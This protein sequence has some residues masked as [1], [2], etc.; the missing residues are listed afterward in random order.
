MDACLKELIK[1]KVGKV[2]LS[3]GKTKLI[4][5]EKWGK[6]REKKLFLAEFCK[7]C[8]D[9]KLFGCFIRTNKLFG[10]DTTYLVGGSLI[11]TFAH[12]LK[13][14]K[15]TRTRLC[16]MR[17][18]DMT[19]CQKMDIMSADRPFRMIDMWGRVWNPNCPRPDPIQDEDMPRQQLDHQ[20]AEQPPP[21]PTSHLTQLRSML[22]NIH[23]I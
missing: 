13:V 17:M 1:D 8:P 9:S 7:G 21:L 20:P 19:V 16:D 15:S 4:Q 12:H 6:K 2:G 10:Y 5:E 22:D 18:T 14:K 23:S 3:L 11:S